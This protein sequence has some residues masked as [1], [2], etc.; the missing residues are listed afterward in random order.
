M[1]I[2]KMQ[3]S[4]KCS[5]ETNTALGECLSRVTSIS[6][7]HERLYGSN[8]YESVN[9]EGY[10][11]GLK[12]QVF[13]LHKEVMNRVDIQ[14][15]LSEA[16]FDM[17]QAIPL[18]LILQELLTNAAKHG[19]PDGRDG[20]I[21]VHLNTIDDIHQLEFRD[22]GVG[23]PKGFDFETSNS[24]GMQLIAA[25]TDQLHGTIE[26]ESIQGTSVVIRFPV[27]K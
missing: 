9:I 11:H 17:N 24:L 26:I 20:S 12:R 23:L 27:K 13:N 19:F 2:I 15:H 8:N 5:K 16:Y 18:G 4:H 1:S 6:M 10:F 7:V 14:T 3:R 22:S 25:L 21:S